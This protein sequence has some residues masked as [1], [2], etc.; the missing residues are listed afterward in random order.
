MKVVLS[1]LLVLVY[2][3]SFSQE[4]YSIRD[5]KAGRFEA[6]RSFIYSLPFGKNKKVFLVQAYESKLSHKGEKALDA[7]KFYRRVN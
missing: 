2:L 6:D 4:Q 5:L 3:R 1:F 7:V